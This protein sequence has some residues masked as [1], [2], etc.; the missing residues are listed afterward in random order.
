MFYVLA[1]QNLQNFAPSFKGLPQDL[2]VIAVDSIWVD[3]EVDPTFVPQ[4]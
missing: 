4:L 2:Q 3:G 1:P